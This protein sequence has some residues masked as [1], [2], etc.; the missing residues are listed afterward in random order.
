MP[1]KI[2]DI[3][4]APCGM[5]CTVC[6]KHVSIRKRGKPCEGCLKGD[7]GKPEHC[8][9]CNI[10]SCVQEKGHVHCFKCADFPCK[11]MKNL[12]KSYIKRYNASLVENGKIADE[13]GVSA[14]LEQD[15][16]KWTCSKCGG[17]FSL[18]DGACSECG[19]NEH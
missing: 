17:A 7:L 6:Y 15:R 13:K 2:E 10:K 16:Q 9:K 4:F 19:N 3:M 12:E 18:H 5:N 1:D 14:F 8:R 11:L